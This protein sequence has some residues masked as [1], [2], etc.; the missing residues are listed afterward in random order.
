V[1]RSVREGVGTDYLAYRRRRD[2][3]TDPRDVRVEVAALLMI[4][5]ILAELD[6]AATAWVQDQLTR[7]AVEIKNTT[8][9][10]RD[11]YMKV[12]EQTSRLERV[13]IELP[14]NE[15]APTE[16][17]DGTP[18]PTFERHM[19]ADST[20]MFPA[21]LNDWETV[22][23]KTEVGRKSTVAWYRNLARA[24]R[25]ALRIAY[26]DESG[27][28]KSL[29]VD[30]VV[31]SRR[32]DG[33]HAASIVDPHGDH[34]ADAKFKLRALADYVRA[35]ATVSCASNRSPR[36]VT[37]SASSTS[38]NL[39]CARPCGRSKSARSPRS[40]SPKPPATTPDGLRHEAAS[41]MV[42]RPEPTSMTSL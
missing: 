12:Q 38:R 40:T 15:V 34:L 10:M 27:N 21:K 22:V 31:V 11:A 26:Q 8:G 7:F 16:D 1:I 24:A 5:E 25:S 36:P 35:T 9:A 32:D 23:V 33:T 17:A 6:E 2:S 37:P 29:Q 13:G 39:R 42:H 3:E 28:L 14:L 41:P 30:F 18:Y 20:G 19:Y 4:K